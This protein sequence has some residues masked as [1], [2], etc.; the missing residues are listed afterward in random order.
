LKPVEE[1]LGLLIFFDTVSPV[2]HYLWQTRLFHWDYWLAS[3]LRKEFDCDF[4]LDLTVD[5]IAIE[6]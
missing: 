6:S 2:F 5:D 4:E 1:A 3:S